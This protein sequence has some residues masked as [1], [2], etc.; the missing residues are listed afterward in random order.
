MSKRKL[1]I[2]KGQGRDD[3]I[4]S[5]KPGQKLPKTGCYL[6]WDEH[7]ANTPDIP[8]GNGYICVSCASR[9]G[10]AAELYEE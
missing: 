5:P 4:I 10:P 8:T 1:G 6:G 9:S 3:L 7:C 2:L